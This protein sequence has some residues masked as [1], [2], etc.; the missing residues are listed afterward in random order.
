MRIAGVLSGV[1]ASVLVIGS[2]W[3]LDSPTPIAPA[4]QIVIVPSMQGQERWENVAVNLRLD[5]LPITGWEPPS[6]EAL[7]EAR[8][9]DWVIQNL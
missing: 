5:P 1:A 2:A 6:R 8:I 4:A 3:L 7:A 9:A